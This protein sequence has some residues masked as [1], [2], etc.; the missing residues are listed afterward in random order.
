MMKSKMN[1][2]KL[3]SIV[4]VVIFILVIAI[5]I[6]RYHH[7]QSSFIPLTDDQM[8]IAKN[9]AVQDM[10]SRGNNVSDYEVQVM[11]KMKRTN[12]ENH[13]LSLVQVSFVN[14]QEVQFY[15]IDL[16]ENKIVMHSE[17]EYY[18]DLDHETHK[19][20]RWFHGMFER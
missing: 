15:L 4:V 11:P 3:I 19:D 13:S 1:T 12:K 2:F 18:E 7:M 16:N 17:T 8:N 20:S 10:Q 9:I 6:W 14:Q 5:G